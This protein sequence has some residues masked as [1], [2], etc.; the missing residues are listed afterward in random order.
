MDTVPVDGAIP[1]NFNW[2]LVPGSKSAQ[3]P[4]VSVTVKFV[5]FVKVGVQLFAVTVALVL[6][7]VIT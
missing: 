4:V 3:A 2:Q 7:I 6:V 1:Y 5:K